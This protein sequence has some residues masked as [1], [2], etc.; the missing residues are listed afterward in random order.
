M[1]GTGRAEDVESMLRE[2]QLGV[3]GRLA[4]DLD[5]RRDWLE[6][7]RLLSMRRPETYGSLT[8]RSCARSVLGSP[9]RLANPLGEFIIAAF[10]GDAVRHGLSGDGVCNAHCDVGDV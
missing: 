1:C 7:F 9:P 4:A 2:R 5:Q 10:R 6:A 3:D 8:R